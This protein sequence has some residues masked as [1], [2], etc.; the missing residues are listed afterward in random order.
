MNEWVKGGFDDEEKSKRNF[1]GFKW[2]HYARAQISFAIS[3]CD[4]LDKSQNFH[5]FDGTNDLLP[6]RFFFLLFAIRKGAK[7]S[8]GMAINL[9]VVILRNKYKINW[10]GRVSPEGRAEFIEKVFQPRNKLAIDFH[11]RPNLSKSQSEILIYDIWNMFMH[12][13]FSIIINYNEEW[14]IVSENI[15]SFVKIM[16]SSALWLPRKIFRCRT[17]QLR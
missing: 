2:Y 3:T 13:N 1:S 16:L 4:D 11:L 6:K 8:P 9:L 7:C 12:Y 15:I 10:T 5:S 14:K 17:K